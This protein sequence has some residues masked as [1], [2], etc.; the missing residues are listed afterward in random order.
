MGLAA[1]TGAVLL[2]TALA[3]APGAGVGVDA[4]T[5]WYKEQDRR[6]KF[7]L[8]KTFGTLRRE[9]LITIVPAP[10][11]KTKVLLTEAGKK[12]VLEYQLEEMR[13]PKMNRWDHVWRLVM[14]DIPE[15]YKKARGALREKIRE[16]GFYQLQ[17]SVWVHPYQC[18]N[19]IDF[20][21]EIFE[22]SPYVRI[23]EATH[24]DGES[25]LKQ[26]FELQ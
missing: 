2:T 3:V 15:R 10:N 7:R 9:R 12:R 6:K 25:F 24:I 13:I 18:R 11:G 21:T 5:K 1:T 14:F 17:K 19:E 23:A 4:F 22:V 20:I 16:F 26:H 8:R